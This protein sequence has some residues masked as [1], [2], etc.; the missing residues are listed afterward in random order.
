M[1]I[2][3]TIPYSTEGTLGDAYNEFMEI[4]P[5][6]DWACFIDHDAM[7]TTGMWKQHMESVIKDYPDYGMFTGVTNRIYNRHQRVSGIETSNHNYIYHKGVGEAAYNQ[8]GTLVDP[9]DTDGYT[10][11]MSGMLILISKDTWNKI[12]FRSGFLGVD[13]AMHV[14]CLYNDINVGRMNG[15][16]IYHYYRG[17]GEGVGSSQANPFFDLDI[18]NMIGDLKKGVS[19][20]DAD[21]K[22]WDIINSLIDENGYK[23]YLEIGVRN[24]DCFDKISCESK[25][26]VDPDERSVS[27]NK[28]TSDEFFEKN[29][30]GF[31][32]I[33]IDGL[34]HA[35]QV[36]TDIINSVKALNP[37]GTIVCHDMN[38]EKKEHQT[39]PRRT[40]RWNGDCWKAWVQL[41][42][43]D[44]GLQDTFKSAFEMF[45]V[46]TDEGC[47]IIRRSDEFQ[48]DLV[49]V[50]NDWDSF[51]DNKSFHLNLISANEFT[52]KTQK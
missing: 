49:E 25:I 9:L 38:P 43:K 11:F 47:G 26:G 10:V 44:G 39:V 20:K 8:Y 5:D 37:G 36:K 52:A 51:N 40:S 46:D 42:C 7:F 32:I 35:E 48:E 33:F 4:V 23:S 34:H 28:C 50:P 13:N 19:A 17:Q 16:Y 1:K 21:V 24:G 14:E 18:Q 30:Q 27:T 12:K 6:G 31:D 29:K 2:H 22:R 3:T 15:L 45:V 41:R